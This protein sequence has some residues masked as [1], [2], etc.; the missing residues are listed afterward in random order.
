MDG[1]RR[2]AKENSL[3][4]FEGHRRGYE[5]L[6]EFSKWARE[7]GIKELVV[8]AFSTE[9]WNRQKT[10]VGFIMNLFR[11]GINS[12]IEDA[13]QNNVRIVFLG[14]RSLLAEDIVNIMER[15]E[16]M[17][18]DN[19]AFRFSIALS[20]GGRAEIIDAIHRIPDGAHKT[21]TE[22]EFSD[23]LWTSGS[24]DPDLIIR[25]SGEERLSNFL[26]WQSVYSELFLTKT[27]WPAFSKE[28]FL[29][30]LKR[31]GERERRRGK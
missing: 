31:Y 6:R 28:E 18:K 19:D 14:E 8:Y 24:M 4:S 23:L 10:E 30:I 12:V 29:S 2:Y 7:A 9:N 27:Y 21:I 13:M 11:S 22:E 15:A 25:T 16:V 20:Y 5:K 26:P 1:N 17:T 3:P